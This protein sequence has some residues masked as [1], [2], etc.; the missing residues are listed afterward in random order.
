MK[1]RNPIIHHLSWQVKEDEEEPRSHGDYGVVVGKINL[2]INI[3]FKKFK[4]KY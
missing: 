2:K 3:I 1:S 4:N